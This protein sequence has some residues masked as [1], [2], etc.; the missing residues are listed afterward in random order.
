[1]IYSEN[2]AL[3]AA[4]LHIVGNKSMSDGV[5]LSESPMKLES[6]IL[7]VLTHYFISS[8]K[9]DERYSFYHNSGLEFNFVYKIVS[10]IFDNPDT[11][12]ESSVMLA[13][14]L[15]DCSEHNKI[16]SGEFCVALFKAVEVDGQRADAV[17][18]FKS[19]K[20]DTYLRVIKQ[21][22]NN[23][24]EQENGIN[25]NKLDKGCLVFNLNPDDGYVVAVIDNTN[26]ME[27]KYW[28]EDFLQAKPRSDEYQHTRSMMSA[29]KSFIMKELPRESDVTKG[30]QA[31]LMD[32][33][34]RYFQENEK[35]DLSDFCSS[36]MGGE[37][38]SNEFE[39]YLDEY[40]VKNNL[41]YADS[42]DISSNAV[43]KS[44]RSMKSVI[45][46]D[47]N[48]HIYVHGGEGLI[49]RGYDEETGME[50]YQ[51]YFKKEE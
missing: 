25:I 19:E 48:F 7:P 45:K 49:K 32:K 9:S 31:E 13:S 28:L 30:D 16:S 37:L 4:C 3:Q 8:F 41:E 43:K 6:S 35:F 10:K 33:T 2:S 11:L 50:Y 36:V 15:Y 44:S 20:K 40:R 47:K 18:L 46:L 1:M 17:G 38:I 24:L 23:I 51:L 29:A 21:N 5:L 42:F 34:L 12:Y 39:S 14:Q 27:A 26:K 22:G